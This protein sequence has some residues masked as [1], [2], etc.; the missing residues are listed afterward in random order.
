[1]TSGPRDAGHG[2]VARKG[3]TMQGNPTA[4]KRPAY[5]ELEEHIGDDLR[6]LMR[7]R[8]MEYIHK[9]PRGK[10]DIPDGKVLVHNRVRHGASTPLGVNGF[11]AWVQFPADDLE[12]CPCPWPPRVS[13]HY[14]VKHED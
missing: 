11:R 13:G 14:R 2:P 3:K 9:L 7:A 5:L 4:E 12:P 1:M 8:G 10:A 6:E